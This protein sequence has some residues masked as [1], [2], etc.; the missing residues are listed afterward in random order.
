[1]WLWKL[2]ADPDIARSRMLNNFLEL[3]DA[4]RMVTKCASIADRVLYMQQS[5]QPHGGTNN[6]C[7]RKSVQLSRKLKETQVATC[8]HN[9]R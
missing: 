6:G 1:V 7:R 8:P 4:A 3:T 5:N 9:W 2:I